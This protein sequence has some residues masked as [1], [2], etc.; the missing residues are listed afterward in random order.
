M[1]NENPLDFQAIFIKLDFQAIFINRNHG[2]PT[3]NADTWLK[4]LLFRKLNKISIRALE[5]KIMYLIGK[6][7][8]YLEEM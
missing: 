2:A 6:G 8:I 5:I 1:C 7:P 4:T 3:S